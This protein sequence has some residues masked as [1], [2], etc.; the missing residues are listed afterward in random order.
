MM[1]APVAPR[2]LKFVSVVSALRVADAKQEG[3]RE[4]LSYKTSDIKINHKTTKWQ[5]KGQLFPFASFLTWYC[6][7]L[8]HHQL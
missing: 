8:H 5:L 6:S 2:E 1:I 7:K 4:R 3:K